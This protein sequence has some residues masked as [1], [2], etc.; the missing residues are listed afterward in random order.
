MSFEEQLEEKA[1]EDRPVDESLRDEL[2]ARIE[3]ALEAD[4]VRQIEE[5]ERL[6]T[7]EEA[8][9]RE[10]EA[11]PLPYRLTY[12]RCTVCH[13]AEASFE[14]RAYSRI[15][16][17]LT[18]LRMRVLNDAHVGPGER[19]QIA[20]YL[21]SAHPVST[22]RAV[23]EV[24]LGLVLLLVLPCSFWRWGLPFLRRCRKNLSERPS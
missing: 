18:I 10:W 2:Q 22:A 17:E 14:A 12:T 1:K 15:G 24:V 7:E 21:A 6:R 8:R 4:R 23:G 19:A 11:R 3:A 16:W 9:R 5:E 20:G 13:T